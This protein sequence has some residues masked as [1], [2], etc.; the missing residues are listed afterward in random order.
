MDAGLLLGAFVMGLASAVHCAG[1]CGGI[2]G[3]CGLG[4]PR[5]AR[6]APLS[7]LVHMLTLN[8]GRIASYS[9]AGGIAGLLGAGTLSLVPGPWAH[10]GLRAMAALVLVAVGLNFLGVLPRL[11]FLERLGVPL[12]RRLDP[13]ARRLMGRRGLPAAFAFGMVWGW[14]PCAIAYGILLVALG[15]G[16]AAGGA[17][18]M[19]AFG[20]GTLPAMV[21]AGLLAGGFHRLIHRPRLRLGLGGV[22]VVLGFLTMIATPGPLGVAAAAGSVCP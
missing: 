14:L 2:A 8:A 10:W 3:A 1:M 22:L 19:A 9:L 11:S 18:V 16:S 7:A 21:G 20:L 5:P 4:L 15:A 6:E 12:W 13:L 17:A